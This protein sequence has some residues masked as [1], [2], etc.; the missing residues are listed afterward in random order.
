MKTQFESLLS[1]QKLLGFIKGT[2]AQPPPT[3]TV[4][5]DGVNIEENN[6][7]HESWF[8]TDQM[9]RSWLFGTFSE[10]VLGSV[11]TLL[12]SR[13]VWLSLAE[14]F[15]KS[16]LS[17]EFSLRRNLQL[18]IK[19][20]KTLSEYCKNFKTICDSLSAIGKHVEESMKI[21]GFLNGLSRE[22]D[23]ITTVIQSSLSKFPAPTFNDV[24][25]EV[26]GF[27]AKLKFYEETTA[28][29]PHLAYTAQAKEG[30]QYHPPIYNPHHRGSGRS[31]YRRGRGG[32]STRGRGFTQHQSAANT[33]GE[34]PTCQI[35]GSVDHTALKC[36]NRFD[37]NYQSA[38]AY[39]S[40]RVA[41]ESGKEWVPDSGASTHITSSTSKLSRSTSISRC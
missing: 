15:N 30:Q 3:R 13:E 35:C 23:P 7:Q 8:C 11:H 41:D 33:Q 31:G 18:I 16:S 29:T 27:D 20:D 9:V 28:V 32:Y 34:R 22:Y 24:I 12:T 6:P 2:T 1:S 39:A 25:T 40:L 36:Y 21:F 10:E 17:R 5:R 19:K 37:N 14:N 26:E 4:V 38:E